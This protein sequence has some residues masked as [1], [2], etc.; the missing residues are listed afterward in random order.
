MWGRASGSDADERGFSLL[1]LAVTL[2]IVTTLAAIAGPVYFRFRA[3]ATRS[4]SFAA[5]KN[6]ALMA[7]S[8][9]VSNGGA[10]E[11]LTYEGLVEEGYQDDPG[12]RVDVANVDTTGYCLTVTNLELPPSSEWHV[13]TFESTTSKPSTADTCG[14]VRA[15]PLVARPVSR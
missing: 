3:D 11:A 9:A 14:V 5:L 13:A 8:W 2:L 10:F 4:H 7:E 15:P 6:A 1:E 12:L